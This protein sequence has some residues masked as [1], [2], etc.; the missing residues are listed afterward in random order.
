MNKFSFLLLL[1]IGCAGNLHVDVSSK[2]QEPITSIH[3]LDSSISYKVPKGF[4]V[5]P[6][7]P[8]V[9]MAMWDKEAELAP[10]IG[11]TQIHIEKYLKDKGINTT[12]GSEEN[13][14][15]APDLFLVYQD[16]W[17]WD[18]KNYL[19]VLK[20]C[21][22]DP[23]TGETIAEGTYRSSEGEFHDFAS[24][25]REVPNILDAIFKQL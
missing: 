9:G 1:F 19:F 22:I 20:I 13:I 5:L 2:Q 15:N 21:L 6:L 16:I 23:I 14:P 25:E 24:S 4:F 8:F 12:Y 11:S 18:F 17:K 7:G 10:G 3:I